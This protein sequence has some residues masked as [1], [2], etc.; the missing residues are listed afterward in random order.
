[1][2]RL[3]LATTALFVCYNLYAQQKYWVYFK[4]KDDASK[5]AQYVSENTIA[6]RIML[7]LPVIQY[8]D[9]PV[10]K[11]YIHSIENSSEIVTVSKWLNAVSVFLTDSQSFK[12][13]TLSY[14]DRV[15]PISGKLLCVG[16]EDAAYDF[17]SYAFEQLNAGVF[18]KNGITAKNVRVGVIDALFIRAN[19]EPNLQNLFRDQKVLGTRD[20]VEPQ[21]NDFF[22]GSDHTKDTHGTT[23]LQY[24]G[25]VNAK[26]GKP[27]GAAKD[28]YYYLA[29]SDNRLKEFRGEEDYWIAAMEWMDSVGVRVINSSLG[30]S[31]DYDNPQE[32]YKPEEMNGQVSAIAKAADI[33]VKEKGLVVVVSSGN[34]GRRADWRILST[35]ADAEGVISVGATDEYGMKR[36]FSSI[37]P[38]FLPYLKPNVSCF[39]IEGTSFSAPV[40]TGLV[41]CM[42]Q[43]NPSLSNRQVKEI[44]E[45]SA[46]LY[47]AG[48]NF[49]GY[50]IPDAAKILLL[51][52]N[53]SS[54]LKGIRDLEA[55]DDKVSL[56]IK[57]TKD[58]AV[59]FHKG[60]NRIVSRQEIVSPE[61]RQLIVERPAELIKHTTAVLKDEVIEIHWK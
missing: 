4:D 48:N 41:A 9:L 10:K 57:K 21:R 39:A 18:K 32:N 1:M 50:G 51:L 35:P 47:S 55:V 59:L 37:G 25:G 34:D 38:D 56:T 36:D 46:H 58:F 22:N 14:V 27:L 33:A 42:I 60:N 13:K 44:I 15:Q 23:V 29:R 8:S 49:L 52:D 28:A 20:F 16:S 24:I 53:P 5:G 11:D 61:G 12:I 40:I 26:T 45:R 43:K 2:R 6:N 54:K 19:T 31:L 17:D 7:E 30:Y 3:T